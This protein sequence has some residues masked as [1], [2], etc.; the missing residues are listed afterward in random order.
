M[1]RFLRSLR[2]KI[3][4]KATNF[5]DYKVDLEKL[6]TAK[7][8]RDFDE[9]YTAPIFGFKNSEDYW[10]QASS[11]PYLLKIKKPTLLITAL[12]D[13]FLAPACYPYEEAENSEMFFLEVSKYGG[14]CGFNL[15]L[16]K[17][18]RWLEQQIIQFIHQNIKLV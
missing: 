7:N 18:H 8:F 11:K 6:K 17:K 14:H 10:E 3:K 15:S 16:F 2:K 9:I 1:E 13:P 12:D 4:E 5:P